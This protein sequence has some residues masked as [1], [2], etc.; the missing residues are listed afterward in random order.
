MSWNS[1]SDFTAR[2]TRIRDFLASQSF[3][4]ISLE[5]FIGYTLLIKD[6]LRCFLIDGVTDPLEL[7]IEYISGKEQ[8]R[9]NFYLFLF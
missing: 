4:P 7:T 2:D 9:Y 8:P 3:L 6:R 1:S 5:T